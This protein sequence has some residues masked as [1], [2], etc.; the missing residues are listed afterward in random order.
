MSLFE[1][2]LGAVNNPNQQASTD[3]L[4][5]I[6][7]AVQQITA[8]QGVDPSTA[9]ATLSMVSG[10]VR[11]AL[12]Q[13]R[14]TG[15]NAAVESILNQF[16]GTRPN[17]G[18]LQALFTP[19]QQ[20][21]ISQAVSQRTGLDPQVVQT[22]LVAMVP[23]VL[24]LLNSGTQTGGAPGQ[25]QAQSAGSNSVLDAFLDADR[26]GDVDISDAIS[27]AGRFLNSPR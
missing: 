11:H 8:S 14:A 9:Q 13:Q 2:I 6:L 3:Q 1:Q 17:P 15:G 22:L 24:N 10:Y 25:P 26:D 16:A 19:A 23:I 5:S 4:S 18:A 12:Q 27:L 21:Q 7:G 20:Q